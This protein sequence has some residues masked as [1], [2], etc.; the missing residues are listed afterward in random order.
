MRSFRNIFS[1][2]ACLFLGLCALGAKRETKPKEAKKEEA[3][4]KEAAKKTPAEGETAMPKMSLPI[5]IGHDAKGLKIPYSEAGK[6]QMIFTIGVANRLDENHLKMTDLRVETFNDDGE[7]EMLIDLPRSV[8]DL[9]TH[10]IST[11]ERATIR[12]S[13]FEITGES[14][15][16]NT[17][18][19]Q[20]KLAG[21]VRMLIYNLAEESA[22]KPEGESP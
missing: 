10:V 13:D 15:Q 3:K 21:N 20:G 17:E 22:A 11:K 8:L 16:F 18:T 6:L 1:L 19:K 5:P 2:L 7:R 14:M 12:R 4:K 9:N